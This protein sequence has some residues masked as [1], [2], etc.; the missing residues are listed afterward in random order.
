MCESAMNVRQRA[1]KM[2]SILKEYGKKYKQIVIVS[3][4][5]TIRFLCCSEFDEKNEPLDNIC[6]KN[7]GILE[8]T[9]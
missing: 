9:L 1:Q 8:K 5:Y 7:C 3:H 6:M 2:K 4:F